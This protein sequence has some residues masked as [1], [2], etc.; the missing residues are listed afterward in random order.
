MNRYI[1]IDLDDASPGMKLWESVMDNKGTPLLPAGTE[2]TPS[3]I[4][5]LQ[6][7]GIDGV[8]IVNDRL[9]EADLRIERE[10]LEKRLQQLFRRTG[11]T[12]TGRMLMQSVLTYRFGEDT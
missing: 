11:N 2:L 12:A 5:S 1:K 8:Q 10:R 6:R 9:T 3:I 4:K 7:R